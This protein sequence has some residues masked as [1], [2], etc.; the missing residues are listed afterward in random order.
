MNHR[1]KFDA[2]SFILGREILNCTNTQNYNKKPT[3]SKQYI[4]TLLIGMCG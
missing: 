1:A 2:P 4:H 3:D